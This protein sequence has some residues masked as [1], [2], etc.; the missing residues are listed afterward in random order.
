MSSDAASSPLWEIFAKT[1]IRRW[2]FTFLQRGQEGIF[3]VLTLREK[4][5]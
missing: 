1:D 3:S 2:S 4:K 5:L